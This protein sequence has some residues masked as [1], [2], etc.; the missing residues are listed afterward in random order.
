MNMDP[1]LLRPLSN[2]LEWTNRSVI[3]T[4][5]LQLYNA[6]LRKILNFHYMH[7]NYEQCLCKHRKEVNDV[8]TS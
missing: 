3:L 6:T 4:Q 7:F 2:S 8:E 5:G 1:M